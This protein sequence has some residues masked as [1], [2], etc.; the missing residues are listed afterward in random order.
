MTKMELVREISKKTDYSVASVRAMLAAME[1]AIVSALK[2][3]GKVEVPGVAI[4]KV[5]RTKATKAGQR[6]IFGEMRR[7]AAKPASLKV[8]VRAKKTLKDAVMSGKK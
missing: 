8:K 5:V 7:V 6:R 1:A 3:S 2:K 4:L